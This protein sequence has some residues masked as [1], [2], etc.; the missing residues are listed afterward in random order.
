[1]AWN[2]ETAKLA[3]MEK[4]RRTGISWGEAAED[5][6]LASR[7]PEEG[8]MDAWYV[9][10]NKEMTEQYVKDAASF[11]K[12]YNLV[13]SEMEEAEEIFMDGDEK[14]AITVYRIRFASGFKVTGL[15]S[16]PRVL[17]SKQGKVILDEAAFVD[18]LD[19]LLKAALALVIW[20][21]VVRVISTHNG[22]D[23][24]FNQLIQDIRAGKYPGAVVHKVPFREAVSQGLFKRICRKLGNEW[25][26]EAEEQFIAETYG[27]YGDKADEELDCIP[28]KSGGA[29]LIRTV[30]EAC[31]D[32]VLPVL[33]WAPPAK[34]F[35][36]WPDES[37]FRDMREWLTGE[38][39]PVMNG[40]LVKPSWFGEDFGRF[41]DLT[42]VAPIQEAFNLT[43]VTPFLLELR[44]CPFT[45][46][47]QALFFLGDRLP[48]FSGGALDAGGNGS[49]LAERAR[50]HWTPD[51]IEQ[52]TLA[53][54]FCLEAY[55]R[56]KSLL[57]DKGL[58][59]PKDDLV[60]DD[61]RAVKTLR[62][63]PRVPRDDR[64]KDK[65]GGKRHGDA[66]VAMAL[67]VWATQRFEAGGEVEYT[68]ART[69]HYRFN[70][71]AW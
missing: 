30:I 28:S 18:N 65:K 67:A 7:L 59:F 2:Q 69:S 26:P 22:E 21:A 4:G 53:D 46:Q 33:R 32:P 14:K 15:V 42:V 64:T 34:D 38:L 44:D 8:G 40:L 31:M 19:E 6:L 29:Y 47:E 16:H 68:P 24:E 51:I 63:V 49:F 1:V 45:Q 62:G 35:V 43:Y 37:R 3:V 56:L 66:A 39:L 17:R 9:S 52:L 70:E 50:Q 54:A 11:A 55:P 61:L 10:Y 5:A 13:A 71:G 48:R 58:S 57:E 25:S 23:N 36:D 60:L 12:F 27:L 20:G 41:V